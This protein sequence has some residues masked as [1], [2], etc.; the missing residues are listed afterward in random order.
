M[1]PMTSQTPGRLRELI[2]LLSLLQ[3]FECEKVTM[4]SCNVFLFVLFLLCLALL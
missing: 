3:A 2:F 1:E 4:K